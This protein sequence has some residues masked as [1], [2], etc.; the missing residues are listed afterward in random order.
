MIG[1]NKPLLVL[2]LA[3][4]IAIA[5]AQ[6]VCT[7]LAGAR[8]LFKGACERDAACRFEVVDNARVGGATVAWDDSPALR[9]RIDD[10][11]F[12]TTSRAF[13]SPLAWLGAPLVAVTNA[14][15]PAAQNCAARAVCLDGAPPPL[16]LQLAV[17]VFVQVQNYVAEDGRCSDLNT[18]AVLAADGAL[19]CQCLPDKVCAP[20]GQQRADTLLTIIETLV[21][22]VIVCQFI[23]VIA[24]GV[25]RMRALQPL[26]MI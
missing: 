10:V 26:K 12:N 21:I 23:G 8:A 19:T 22:I 6:F 17:A 5:R 18:V 3:L 11:L 15:D 7:D 4:F 1:Q 20:S 14:S 9:A 24:L 25:P 16:E 13:F 2:L